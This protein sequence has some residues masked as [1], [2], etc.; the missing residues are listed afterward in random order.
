MMRERAEAA[1]AQL[2]VTSQPGHGTE[3][4]LHWT[5]NPQKETNDKHSSPT[6]SRHAG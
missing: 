4:I 1:G 3:L 6:H 5:K 2:T